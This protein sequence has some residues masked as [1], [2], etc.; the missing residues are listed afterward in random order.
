MTDRLTDR[1]TDHTIRSF[2]IGV[3]H[4]GDVKVCYCLRLKEVFIGAVDSTDRINFSNQQLYVAVKQD[5][6]DKL[7]CLWRQTTI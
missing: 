2:T 1:P 6:I 4:S 7:Q 3:E 5:A